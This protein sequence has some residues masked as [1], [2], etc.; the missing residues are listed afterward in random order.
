[1]TVLNPT[2]RR[3]CALSTGAFLDYN[4]FLSLP[5]DDTNLYQ[6]EVPMVSIAVAI[7][8]LATQHSVSV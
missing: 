1:M 4:E 3:V 8:I 6:R 5:G 2:R 7:D